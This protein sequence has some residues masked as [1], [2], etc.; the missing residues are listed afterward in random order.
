MEKL[1]L[2]VHSIFSENMYFCAMIKGQMSERVV[3][4]PRAAIAMMEETV[5]MATEFAK[6]KDGNV[7]VVYDWEPEDKVMFYTISRVSEPPTF[8]MEELFDYFINNVYENP[9]QLQ[10]IIQEWEIENRLLP[11][12]M[13][14]M[15]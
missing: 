10:E 13:S 3:D 2:R 8:S 5:K 14:P 1:I 12:G 9:L 6:W 4:R 15:E 7:M 11:G